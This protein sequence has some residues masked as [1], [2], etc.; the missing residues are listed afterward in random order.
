MTLFLNAF[1]FALV[2]TALFALRFGDDVRRR[3]LAAYFA[4]FFGLEWLAARYFFP[5]DAIG[6][7]LAATCF[8][9]TVPIAV[10]IVLIRRSQ[11]ARTE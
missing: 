9:L 10:A 2:T 11:H 3:T 6:L 8:A 7:E 5:P 4:F 1:G